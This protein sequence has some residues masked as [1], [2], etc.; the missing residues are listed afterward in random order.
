VSLVAG[1]G[2]TIV[3]KS[4]YGTIINLLQ[5]LYIAR[6]E[7]GESE[8]KQLIADCT[9]PE[10]L[11]LFGLQRETPTSEYIS[12]DLLDEKNALDLHEHLVQLLIRVLDASAGSQGV[13]GCYVCLSLDASISFRL[14][15]RLESSMDESR[16]VYCIST[17]SCRP[18][19]VIRR[20]CLPCRSS[21]R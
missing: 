9:L 15:E 21:G 18:D 10:N 4:V 7:D 13:W 8:I 19:T 1:E 12:L 16:H 5:S 20:P 6:P 2:P 3:R 17:I 14:A 11:K